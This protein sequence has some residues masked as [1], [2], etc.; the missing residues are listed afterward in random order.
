MFFYF[1]LAFLASTIGAIVGL[2]GGLIIKPSLSALTLLP[3]GNI[4]L[5]SSITVFCMSC[6]SLI[7]RKLNNNIMLINNWKLLII[8]SI[9]GGIIGNYLFSLLL[10]TA[11]ESTLNAVQSFLIIILLCIALSSSLI[12][13]YIS[14][15][16]HLQTSKKN[17]FITGIILS[18]ISSFLSVGGGPSNVAILIIF[19]KADIKTA[20]FTSILIILFSQGS[21]LLMTISS[22]Q[23]LQYNLIPALFM[24]PG[25]IMGGIVGTKINHMCNP[26]TIQIIF[27]ITI[28]ILILLNIF[29]A[30]K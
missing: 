3:L 8:G 15:N 17:L 12:N 23:Y 16:M 4:N 21:N 30:F 14:K 2:G 18:I 13:K 11:N 9:L 29:V 26:K 5:L 24:I 25:G 7:K 6:S 19:F 1:I 27:N 28:S 10:S 20:T 22:G